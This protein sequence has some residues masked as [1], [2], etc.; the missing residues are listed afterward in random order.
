MLQFSKFAPNKKKSGRRKKQKA[1]SDTDVSDYESCSKRVKYVSNSTMEASE[2]ANEEPLEQSVW[3]EH[4]PNKVL[5]RIFQYTSQDGSL[6]ILVRYE[7]QLFL[8]F[9]Q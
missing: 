8:Y 3:G 9:K 1:P 6:P 2:A 7:N 4:L 5:Y